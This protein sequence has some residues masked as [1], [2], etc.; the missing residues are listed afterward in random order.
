MADPLGIAGTA[1]GLVSLGLQLYGEISKYIKAVKGRDEDLR[2]ARQN[3][4][5]L[6]KCLNAIKGATSS[7]NV[8]QT[9]SKDAVEECVASCIDEL[10]QLDQRLTRLRGSTTPA[11]SLSAKVKA[12]G[13]QL[14]YPFHKDDIVDLERRLASANDVLQAALHA[15][16]MP[17][18]TTIVNSAWA[19]KQEAVH[20][21]IDVLNNSSDPEDE[22]SNA[23]ST[24]L[25]ALD[26]I[27]LFHNFPDFAK[28]LHFGSLMM[29][30]MR[31]DLGYVSHLLNTSP[32]SVH[33]TNYCGQTPVHIAVLAGNASILKLVLSFSNEKLLHM[34]DSYDHY[35]IEYVT[36]RQMHKACHSQRVSICEGCM[37]LEA[38]LNAGSVLFTHALQLGLGGEDEVSQNLSFPV[39]EIL[40]RHLKER[41]MRLQDL[42]IKQ[43]TKGKRRG[44]ISPANYVLDRNATRL[45]KLLEDQSTHIPWHLKVYNR[46]ENTE[47]SD[48][49]GTIYGYICDRTTAKLAWK[50]GFRD[51][52]IDFMDGLNQV[53]R[54][55]LTSSGTHE[56]A[57]QTISGYILA[58]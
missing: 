42:A 23:Y 31:Q 39:R 2:A 43:L 9:A 45:Q 50:L 40:L 19:W 37:M 51:V 5:V 52:G 13:R 20:T 58:G 6:R 12:K 8:A 55:V 17:I 1:A 41:R 14:M 53:L 22:Y 25:G 54:G 21:M 57:S 27:K 38:L 3:A 36:P 44:L 30:I 47:I 32:L 4:E 24:L 34:A 7:T 29:G 28:R 10:K 26:T 15:L 48:S 49:P 35:P 46:H 11:D 56:Q 18:Y 16:G 33:E